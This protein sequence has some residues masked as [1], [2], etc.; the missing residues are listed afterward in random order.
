METLPTKKHNLV[1]AIVVL[2][3]AGTLAWLYLREPAPLPRTAPRPLSSDAPRV[4]IA[5]DLRDRAGTPLGAE[6]SRLVLQ[7]VSSGS[8]SSA[9]SP[10]SSA[11]ASSAQSQEVSATAQSSSATSS[12]PEL[13]VALTKHRI[14]L[15]L[16]VRDPE[17]VNAWLDENATL[18][19]L[20]ADP[21]VG[22]AWY[23]LSQFLHVRAEDLHLDGLRGAFLL[24]ALREILAADFALHYDYLEG[25]NGVVISFERTKA[26]AASAAL[27]TITHALA[28]RE[29]HLPALAAPIFE[30]L[31]GS[32]TVF[33]TE[34]GSRVYA[35]NGIRS[36][37]SV[38]D[39]ALVPPDG[40]PAAS[41][42]A[43]VRAATFLRALLPVLAGSDDWNLHIGL[44]LD[45]DHEEPVFLASDRA[46]VLQLLT[47]A[48]NP[49][50]LASIPR[51]AFAGF[52]AS[53][54]ADPSTPDDAWY[55]AATDLSAPLAPPTVAKGGFGIVWDFDAHPEKDDAT[56]G[57]SQVGYI[58]A[59]PDSSVTDETLAS[60]FS[61]QTHLQRCGGGTIALA[62]LSPL[63]TT[64]MKEACERQSISVLSGLEKAGSAVDQQL[65]LFVNAGSAL[66]SLYRAGS[67]NTAKARQLSDDPKPNWKE[68]YDAAVAKASGEAERFFS[69]LPP[70]L[71]AG[72]AAGGGALLPAHFLT[73]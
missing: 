52:A 15:S 59:L 13:A 27:P 38:L 16:W 47:P 32:Q 10:A 12:V 6:N 19:S 37:L 30:L 73:F 64:R 2:G 48:T 68:A 23:E 8:E 5:L 43:T 72:K 7:Q 21:V 36:L 65:Y 57:L 31:I 44:N 20:L 3:L 46:R 18:K 51:D 67:S 42:V 11:A 45:R 4:N 29:F 71:F 70:V 41:A 66:Q 39:N 28:R 53:F 58:I 9:A 33:V 17:K 69:S 22:G 35:T 63:L 55:R 56:P 40:L 49:G 25:K 1:R 14:A 24:S 62:S 34:D 54:T 60:Y 26:P 61:P 50:V